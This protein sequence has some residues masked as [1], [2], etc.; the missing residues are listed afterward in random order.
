MRSIS[1]STCAISSSAFGESVRLVSAAPGASAPST[2]ITATGRSPTPVI[3][4][5]IQRD[6]VI[7]D[8]HRPK[9]RTAYTLPPN[10]GSRRPS[11][12]KIAAPRR[13]EAERRG[14]DPWTKRTQILAT[15]PWAPGG[16]P[17]PRKGG[18]AQGVPAGAHFRP[19]H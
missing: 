19:G 16:R 11:A 10:T 8:L 1:A 12:Q 6:L 18:D 7:L 13:H 4:A 9:T 3:K 5:F 17:A 15:T 2:A 14:D